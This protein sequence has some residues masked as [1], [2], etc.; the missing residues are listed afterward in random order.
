MEIL[1][2]T[3]M[4]NKKIIAALSLFSSAY[5]LSS[6]VSCNFENDKAE[7]FDDHGFAAEIKNVEYVGAYETDSNNVMNVSPSENF[8][9]YYALSN[10]KDYS[11]EPVVTFPSQVSPSNYSVSYDSS[12]NMV[13][14]TYKK[15][16]LATVDGTSEYDISPMMKVINVAE[17]KGK[18][19]SASEYALLVQ[20]KDYQT[21][22]TEDEKFLTLKCNAAPNDITN[23]IAQMITAQDEKLVI[24]FDMPEL[25]NDDTMLTVYE[26]NKKKT[27][28]F[29]ISSRTPRARTGEAWTISN[30]TE[31]EAAG[32]YLDPTSE[33]GKIFTH[34][35]GTPYYITTDLTDITTENVFSIKMKIS[36]SYGLTSKELTITSR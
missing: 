2:E 19:L 15:S 26:T 17:A 21:A 33:G 4:K 23:A 13:A 28:Y 22:H 3:Y 31:W 9:V 25:K 12:K 34:T 29:T 27:H 10:P 16:F 36:D 30:S 7:Y 32:E 18:N 14:L 1:E 8:T 6:I 20:S 5:I 35:S 24:A 11:V